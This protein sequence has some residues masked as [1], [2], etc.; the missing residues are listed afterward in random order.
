MDSTTPG[1]IL[2][3]IIAVLAIIGALKGFTR[4]I[5]RQLLRTITIIIS[6]VIATLIA[7]GFFTSIASELQGK[8]PEELEA[9]IR[10]A[11]VFEQDADLS[12]LE[13]LDADTI[14]LIITIPMSLL[15]MPIIF[16]ISFIIISALMLIVHGILATLFGLRKRRNNLVTR[17]LGMALG[18]IQGVA[19]AGFILMPIIGITTSVRESV[20]VLKEKAPN[21]EATIVL[22]DTYDTYLEGICEHPSVSVLGTLGI[23]SLYKGIATVEIDGKDTDMTKLLPDLAIIV[24]NID[25]LGGADMS[26]LTPENEAAINN[27]LDTIEN[28]PYLTNVLAGTMKMVSHA[29]TNGAMNIDLEEPLKSILDAAISIFHTSDSTNINTDMETIKNVYFILSRDEILSSFDAGSDVMLEKLTA[30]DADGTTTVKKVINTIN[31]NERTKPLVTLLTKISI[32]VMSQQTGADGV[33][34]EVYDNVKSGLNETLQINKNDFETEEEYVAAVSDSLDTTLKENN[35][36]LEKDIVDSMAEYVSENLSDKEEITD[37]DI[38]DVIIS[39]YDAYLEYLESGTV[40]DE[41]PD[42]IFE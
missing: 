12:W 1:L 38:N 5:S 37:D 27:I 36:N 11:N 24:C 22:S 2:F 15:I 30:K 3:A 34:P 4:G 25:E 20:E 21:E 28:N 18:F 19:V 13:N 8:T 41:I 42:G 40:P 16:V 14:L 29:Y 9:I 32:T 33:S 7:S 35:I 26:K 10:S 17:L 39:Y 31:E 6:V 23:N